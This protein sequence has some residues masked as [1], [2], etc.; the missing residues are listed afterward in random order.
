MLRSLRHYWKIDLAVCL[1]AAAATS[2]LTGALLV[3]DSVRGSLRDLTLERLGEIDHALVSDRGFFREELAGQLS[4]GLAA[5][6]EVGDTGVVPAI[7]LRGTAIHGRTKARASQ[8]QILGIDH[9]FTA[10]YEQDRATGKSRPG[11]SGSEGGM[12]RGRQGQAELLARESSGSF[13][14]VVINGSLQRELAAQIGDSILLSFE[15]LSDVHR[16]SLYGR[17]GSAEVVQTLRLSVSGI[18]P[19][20]GGGRFALRPHQGLPLNAFVPL[21]VLQRALD[22]QGA[23]NALFATSPGGGANGEA[24]NGGGGADPQA[25]L[26]QTVS[27]A[28]V[29][30]QLRRELGHG[31]LESSQLIIDPYL[32]DVAQEAAEELGLPHLPALT[33]LAISLELD[34]GVSVPYSTVTALDPEELVGQPGLGELKLTD[35][36]PAP[37]LAADEILLTRWA[38]EDLGATTGDEIALAYYEVGPREEL[39]TRRARLALRG[40][41]AMEGLAVDRSLTPAYP[42][43]QETDDMSAWSAPFP[44]DL[45][46]VRP[47]DEDYWDDFGAAPKAFVSRATGRRLWGSRFGEMTSLRIAAV[48]GRE[49]ASAAADFERHLL[50]KINAAR[51]GMVFQPVKAQGLRA[52]AGATQ[53]F[54]M[55]FIGF[56]MFLIVSAALLVGLLFRLGVEQ[57]TQ[58]MGLLLAT[59]FTVAAVRR[60][61]L[62]EGAVLAGT[63]GAIGVAGAVGCAWLMMA[64]LRTWWLAAVGTPFLFLHVE[65][66]SLVIGYVVSLLVVLLSIGWSVRRYGRM[67]ASVL[68]AGEMGAG[69]AGTVDGRGQGA[70]RRRLVGA[71]AAIG[72]SLVLIA[73]AAGSGPAAAAALFFGSGA[74]LLVSGLTFLSLWL[75]GG[76]SGAAAL[77]C[78]RWATMRMGWRNSQRQPGRSMLCAALVASACFVIVAV[79]ANRRTEGTGPDSGGLDSGTGGYALVAEAEVPLYQDLNDA[80]GRFELGLSGS[81]S[82]LLTDAVVYQFRGLPGEDASCLN[83]YKPEQPR[84]LGAPVGFIRRG[85]FGFKQVIDLQGSEPP[86]AHSAERAVAVVDN[87]WLLLDEDLG[88]GVIPAIGDYNSVLWILHLGLGEELTI[89]DE[90]G[91]EVRLRLVALLESSIFQSELVI[92]AASLRKYFPGQGGSGFFLIETAEAPQ[93]SIALER[94][95]GEYG[96]DVESAADRLAGFQAVE[97]T[98]LSTFAVLG[99]LGLLLGT[100]G[101]GIILVRNAIERSAE[102]AALRAFG[103]RRSTLS[104]M[105]LTESGFLLAVGILIGSAAAVLAAAPHVI[106]SPGTIA[107]RPL[108]GTLAAVVLVGMGASALAVRFALPIPL[109]QP[110]KGN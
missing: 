99:G 32:G 16:E 72:L 64:G 106:S 13:P 86:P 105:L 69:A 23:V 76:R 82:K 27:L 87:P 59:G 17:R 58:E 43:M 4:D 60:R 92:S 103:F 22:Q 39:F 33:Y 15:R 90:S 61:L 53:D 70:K 31:S 101:L 6:S 107:L 2:V 77:R 67:P 3:G 35:G 81:D 19:D 73:L 48:P 88:P 65:W 74:L 1:G 104:L 89:R 47:K 40:V 102:L 36:S 11:S 42:G 25:A 14:A 94:S 83:L 100:V 91:M 10:L 56:S 50:G 84:V 98:Y 5:R 95:L 26:E 108:F 37:A 54:S 29:G 62:G 21:Q 44:V 68:L 24:A 96:L 18:V 45:S 97:S 20:R 57:R 93:L 63:G 12:G 52:G 30:L 49:L 41:V 66:G 34:G 85:G 110:L 38:A 78:G 28:D 109:L 80:E 79:G 7:L 9:R 46:R 55:L 71:L 8:I 75:R 51:V